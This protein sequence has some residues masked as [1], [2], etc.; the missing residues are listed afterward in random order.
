IIYFSHAHFSS[1][2]IDQDCQRWFHDGILTGA[3]LRK[4]STT[5]TQLPHAILAIYSH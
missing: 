2:I 1:H 3:N 4:E 5:A